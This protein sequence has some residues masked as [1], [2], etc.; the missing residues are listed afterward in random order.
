MWII[1]PNFSHGFYHKSGN[2][3]QLNIEILAGKQI[4]TFH[5]N[6]SY[7]KLP[8]RTQL[9]Y[10]NGLQFIFIFISRTKK[11]QAVLPSNTWTT[12]CL[13]TTFRIVVLRERIYCSR[14]VIGQLVHYCFGKMFV[15]G[16]GE[17]PFVNFLYLYLQD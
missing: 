6:D 11:W 1:L 13:V 3:K 12:V 9:N 17:W 5:H 7:M 4:L 8:N 16:G 14:M 10:V 15:L 2:W